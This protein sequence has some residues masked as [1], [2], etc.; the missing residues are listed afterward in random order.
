MVLPI[1]TFQVGAISLT[2]PPFQKPPV[3]FKPTTSSLPMKCSITELKRQMNYPIIQD[4]NEALDFFLSFSLRNLELYLEA[5]DRLQN[6]GL[7][8]GIP[9][10]SHNFSGFIDASVVCQKQHE[11]FWE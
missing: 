1:P 10:S 3:G 2:L 6:L 11:L 9:H 5:H 7:V 4:N 8:V